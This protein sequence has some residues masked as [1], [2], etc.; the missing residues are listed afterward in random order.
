MGMQWF[1]FKTSKFEGFVNKIDLPWCC[2]VFFV[3]C[4]P[5]PRVNPLRRDFGEF[6]VEHP[7]P[8]ITITRR[9]RRLIQGAGK[10]QRIQHSTRVSQFLL[11]VFTST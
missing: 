11:L 4:L 2:V 3:V 7:N 8:Q 9:N 1:C 6:P 5:A 10:Q